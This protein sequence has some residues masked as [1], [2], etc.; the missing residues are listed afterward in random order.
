VKVQEPQNPNY[1]ATVV[2]LVAINELENCDNVVGTPLFG[3]Q[4]IVGKATQVGD[5]GIMFPPEVQLSD[6]F[7]RQNNLYRHPEKNLSVEAK[8]YLEDNRRVKAMKFRGHMSNCLFMPLASVAWAGVEPKDLAEG[9]VF[10]TLNGKEICR[11]YV[12]KHVNQPGLPGSRT[13]GKTKKFQRVDAL[14]IPEHMDS[15]NYFRNSHHIPA[16]TEVIVTQKIHGTSVRIANTFVKRQLNWKERLAERFGVKVQQYEHDYVFASRRV[17]KDENNAGG[18]YGSHDVW[19]E[20]GEKLRHLLPVGCVVYGEI[21]G[22]TSDGGEIQKGY[23]YDCAPGAHRMLVYRVAM[24]NEQGFLVDLSWDLV[25]EFCAARGLHYVPELWR[26]PH[27]NFDVNEWLDRR[28]V[29]MGHEGPIPTKKGQV[30]EGV[31]VRVDRINPYILKAKSPLFLIH[32]SNMHDV[33]AV[34]MEAIG[35][36]EVDQV[37]P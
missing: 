13:R 1:A 21:I 27:E 30:D 10:D 11:K 23:T 36:E 24:V 8:G 15:E 18:F 12:V 37:E 22:Y 31:C 28:F 2:R 34:D 19:T 33:G 6:E 16:D 3:Y 4:S 25:K 7:C 29:D 5:I 26:G 17:I 9:M 14:H 32:E 35:S 20:A